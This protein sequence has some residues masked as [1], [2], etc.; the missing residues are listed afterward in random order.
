M[1]LLGLQGQGREDQQDC[2]FCTCVLLTESQGLKT[3]SRS[4]WQHIAA[5]IWLEQQ[6]TPLSDPSKS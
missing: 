6:V 3:S 2:Y 5:G 4:C 1:E